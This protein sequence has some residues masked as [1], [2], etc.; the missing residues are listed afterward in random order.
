MS[1]N[2]LLNSSRYCFQL[3]GQVWPTV[4]HY[5]ES[6]AKNNSNIRKCKTPWLASRKNLKYVT[7]HRNGLEPEHKVVVSKNNEG[8]KEFMMKAIQ[9]KF[10]QNP[11]LKKRLLKTKLEDYE[12]EDKDLA[13]IMFLIKQKI[14]KENNKEKDIENDA[15]FD[16]E[17]GFLLY[18][19]QLSE[20]IMKL[21]GCKNIESGMV[22]DSI[23]NI[24][25]DELFEEFLKYK[26]Q[27]MGITKLPC[28][29]KLNIRVKNV[30]KNDQ[31]SLLISY[32]LKF[33]REKNINT[34]KEVENIKL[35]PKKRSYRKI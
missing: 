25:G 5:L 7:C 28:L 31:Y 21:E 6:K 9:E 10:N 13:D 15:F 12:F 8:R 32:L 33:L 29:A 16:W 2:F 26:K 11:N 24:L 35:Y 17:K 23:Y 19:L 3:E 30:V 22:E 20:E 34:Y 1:A 27:T 14:I 4:T 18:I